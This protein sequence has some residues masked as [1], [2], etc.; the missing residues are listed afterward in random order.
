[1]IFKQKVSVEV[2]TNLSVPAIKKK[3]QI[4]E[5]PNKGTPNKVLYLTMNRKMTNTGPLAKCLFW[6]KILRKLDQKC[7]N[8]H[9]RLLNKPYNHLY[10]PI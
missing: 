3:L 8:C 6:V 10:G 7:N 9:S 2:F 5:F 1:M 4:R